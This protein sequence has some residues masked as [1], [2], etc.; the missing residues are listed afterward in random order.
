MHN[1]LNANDNYQSD[2]CDGDENEDNVD[3]DDEHK[4]KHL[5]PSTFD[6]S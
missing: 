5:I 1:R 2:C 4:D 6:L 3:N